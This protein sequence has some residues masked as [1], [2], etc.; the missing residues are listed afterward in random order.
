MIE[1]SQLKT[2]RLTDVPPGAIFF[3]TGK[4]QPRL[5]CG[6]I[7]GHVVL[8]ALEGVDP[9]ADAPIGTWPH[10][11]GLIVE[12]Y[13][14]QVDHLSAR[15]INATLDAPLGSIILGSD[16]PV[17][18]TGNSNGSHAVLLAAGKTPGVATK[19]EVAFTS[20]RFV[21]GHGDDTVVLFESEPP[22]V[23][24]VVHKVD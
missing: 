9:F 3:P 21:T 6:R 12:R 11:R 4:G 17:L 20:W 23:G 18:R 7:D 22:I 14:V 8:L 24:V 19:G 1:I 5:L 16:G 2:S 13:R 15:S 10:A